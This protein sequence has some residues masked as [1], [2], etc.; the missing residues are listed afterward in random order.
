[1]DKVYMVQVEIRCREGADVTKTV[2]NTYEKA[3]E[4]FKQSIQK[5]KTYD[6]VSDVEWVGDYPDEKDADYVV[7]HT[8]DNGKENKEIEQ[9]WQLSQ[10]HDCNSICV[11]LEILGVL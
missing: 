8:I 7:L 6:W 10:L 5:M 2:F 11:T 3:Y 9:L 1:M 4:W